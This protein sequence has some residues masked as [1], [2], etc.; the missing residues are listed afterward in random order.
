MLKCGAWGPHGAFK[1]GGSSRETGGSSPTASSAAGTRSSRPWGARG[2]SPRPKS[3]RFAAGGDPARSGQRPYPSG[4]LCTLRGRLPRGASMSR[5][6]LALMRR[7]GSP[8]RLPEA[9]AAGA[10]EALATGTTALA[11]ISHDNGAWRVL[12]NTPLRK[13]CLAE[14]MGFGPFRALN[15]AGFSARLDAL[16]PPDDRLKFGLT[17]HAPYSTSARLYRK[18][19]ALA[20]DRGWP[21]ATA[22]GGNPRRAEAVDGR[23]PGLEGPARRRPG[24]AVLALAGLQADGVCPERRIPR[25]AFRPGPPGPRELS[26]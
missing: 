20:R 11:D 25:T 19:A 5:W 7:R 23:R 16:P 17:P 14:V 22:P 26:R 2:R 8:R 1:P 4:A 6:M 24:R 12:R 13:L 21:L 15:P 9:V 10:R 3:S 18:A